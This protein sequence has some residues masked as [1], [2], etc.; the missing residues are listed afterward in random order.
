MESN[1][2]DPNYEFYEEK[3]EYSIFPNS[4]EPEE[5]LLYLLAE[6]VIIV[7][8]GW[9]DQ[10]WPKDKITISVICNDIFAWGCADAEDIEYKDLETIFNLH[11]KDPIWGI[12]SWCIKKRKQ[13]PQY[14]VERDMIEAGYDIEKLIK[15]AGK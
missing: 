12:A 4:M 3:R 9:W 7:N 10:N 1:E 6:G 14:P 8:N 2:N 15:G 13:R 11:R 5:Y